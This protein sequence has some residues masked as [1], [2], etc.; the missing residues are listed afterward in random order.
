MMSIEV[1]G[2]EKVGW[3]HGHGENRDQL[4]S[5]EHRSS[6]TFWESFYVSFVTKEDKRSQKM[7]HR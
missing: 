3:L 7:L 6:S 1:E 4:L 2:G 5:V